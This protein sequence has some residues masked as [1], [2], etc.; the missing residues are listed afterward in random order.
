[1]GTIRYS[2]ALLVGLC[3]AL[4]TGL[5]PGAW[6]APVAGPPPA[7]GA[8]VAVPVDGARSLGPAAVGRGPHGALRA[9]TDL[10][11]RRLLTADL[12]AAAK[13][14]TASPIDDAERERQV[15]ASVAR[16]ARAVGADP[17][18]TVT[19]FRD[20][21]EANKAVQRALH[22][23]WR[24]HPAEAPT[25]RPELTEVRAEINRLND[26]LVG[27]IAATEPDR[28]APLCTLALVPEAIRASR[29]HRLDG[30]HGLAFVR[31]LRSVCQP[32]TAVGD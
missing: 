31:G 21:I 14:G 19:I 26:G 18:A 1:M 15:L 3:A 20:Q 5:G 12:V 6:A 23:R 29:T 32:P 9:L 13:W 22:R 30:P 4:A 2:R 11:A 10:A 17:T 8:P 28:A 16:R 7:A 27:A 24:A 25:G